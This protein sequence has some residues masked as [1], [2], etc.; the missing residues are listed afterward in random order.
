MN[1]VQAQTKFQAPMK[2]PSFI[3]GL[4]AIFQSLDFSTPYINS[5]YLSLLSS[6]LRALGS[7]SDTTLR[8]VGQSFLANV[9][10]IYATLSF[11]F[12]LLPRPFFYEEKKMKQQRFGNSAKCIQGSYSSRM[13]PKEI[14]LFTQTEVCYSRVRGWNW[15]LL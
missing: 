1:S 7:P 15:N 8:L 5:F 3:S 14:S 9:P 12:S 13:D 10:F 2:A 11:L 4:R 6:P